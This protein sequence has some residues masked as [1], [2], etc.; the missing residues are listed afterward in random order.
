MFKGL[1][2]LPASSPEIIWICKETTFFCNEF[3]TISF[4]TIHIISLLHNVFETCVFLQE[5][6]GS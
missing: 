3:R 4:Y 6:E 2:F 5:L 1:K